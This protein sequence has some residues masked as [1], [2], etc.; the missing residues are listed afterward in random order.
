[1][2]LTSCCLLTTGLVNGKEPAN[3]LCCVRA[4]CDSKADTESFQEEN[5]LRGHGLVDAD[6]ESHAIIS[7]SCFD[8]LITQGESLS[9]RESQL[10]ERWLEWETEN[11]PAF[12]L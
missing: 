3:S 4:D 5:V 11:N 12:Q 10:G 9:H 2:W 7:D 8:L 6:F 1:M